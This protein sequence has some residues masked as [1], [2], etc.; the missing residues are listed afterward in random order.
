MPQ[1]PHTHAEAVSSTP[2]SSSRSPPIALPSS[3]RSR[4]STSAPR[5]PEAFGSDRPRLV[6]EL[7]EAVRGGVDEARRAADEHPRV[8]GRRPGDLLEQLAVDAPGIAGPAF[9]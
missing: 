6:S 9:G 8:L 2:K 7:D 1:A 3:F 4:V 5:C